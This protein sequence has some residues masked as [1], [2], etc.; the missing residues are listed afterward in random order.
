MRKFLYFLA[1]ILSFSVTADAQWNLGIATS[2]WMSTNST[3]PE[4][5]QHSQIVVKKLLS[6]YFPL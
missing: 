6:M 4:S 1:T 5:R 2:D 3:L